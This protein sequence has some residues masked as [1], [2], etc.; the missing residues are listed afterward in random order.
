[1][2]YYITWP[3]LLLVEFQLDMMH[4]L[5]VLNILMMNWYYQLMLCANI[6]KFFREYWRKYRLLDMG[7]HT[8]YKNLMTIITRQLES[9]YD[10][11]KHVLSL[12]IF[13]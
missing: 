2:A 5:L 13:S 10:N 3:D 9:Y 4:A 7:L 8:Q 6:W 11:Y 1:M 12:W